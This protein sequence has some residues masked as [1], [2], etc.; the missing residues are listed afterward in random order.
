MRKALLLMTPMLLLLAAAGCSTEAKKRQAEFD[1]MIKKLP[2]KY[3]NRAQASKDASGQLAAVALLIEPVNALAVGRLVM[4][5][6]ET[7]VD[8]SRRVFGQ[9]I[10]TFEVDKKNSLVQTVYVLKDPRRW[11]NAGDDPYVIQSVLPDD[12]TVMSGCELIWSKTDSGFKA[13]TKPD[14]CKASAVAQGTLVEQSAELKGS[15]LT[16]GEQIGGDDEGHTST[17]R[18]E[19]H[20]TES[21]QD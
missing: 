21:H 6:R 13:A 12:L 3:D 5:E 7:A 15:E 20:A 9:H 18:F 2:G 14:S 19:R 1:V 4:F 16:L 11:M 10:W 8:D 17:Y